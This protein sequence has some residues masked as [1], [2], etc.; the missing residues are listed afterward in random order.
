MEQEMLTKQSGANY[1][2]IEVTCYIIMDL[3]FHKRKSLTSTILRTTNIFFKNSWTKVVQKKSSETK[4]L[5]DKSELKW[6]TCDAQI[7]VLTLLVL[8]M[9]IA[10]TQKLFSTSFNVNGPLKITFKNKEMRLLK[11]FNQRLRK[12]CLKL[13]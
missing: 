8:I 6:S 10:D 7:H 11:F 4:Y 13:P 1:I 3:S 12:H 2:V 5:S 9:L